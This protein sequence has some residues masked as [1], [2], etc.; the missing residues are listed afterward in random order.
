MTSVAITGATG[1]VGSHLAA[2]FERDGWRVVRT[3]FRLGDE[4]K[5]DEL[6][7]CD[8]LVHCAYDFRPVAWPDIKRIN[9]DGSRKLLEAAITGGV[10]RIVVLSTISAF[11]GCRSLYGKAKLQI[12]DLG[13]QSGAAVLRPGLVYV[14][15]GSQPGGMY[16]S[17]LQSSRRSLVPLIDGGVH[18]QYLAHIDDLYAAVRGLTAGDIPVPQVPVVVASPRCWTMRRLLMLFARRQGRAPLFLSVPW[19]AVWLGLKTAELVGLRPAY[20]S[21]SVV[22]LVFQDPHPD[23]SALR[24]LGLTARDFSAG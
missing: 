5:P 7:G 4:V 23:F 8:A 10:A 24:A 9:V 11:Q 3:R 18:C 17:L 20:R 15:D 19:Q 13:E 2:G 16:G 22:S 12:E 14:D 21:D 6:A 1:Y